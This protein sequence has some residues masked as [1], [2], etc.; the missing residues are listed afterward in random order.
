MT[1]EQ[2][3][4]ILYK[5]VKSW[6]VSVPALVF[7]PQVDAAQRAA[8]RVTAAGVARAPGRHGPPLQDRHQVP[9]LP[10]QRQDLTVKTNV[11]ETT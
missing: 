6:F 10:V 7:P 3:Q 1:P 5:G 2:N 9:A 8:A 11:P 4:N